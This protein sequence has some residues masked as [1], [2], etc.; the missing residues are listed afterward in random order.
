MGSPYSPYRL[1]PS[2]SRGLDDPDKGVDL[3]QKDVARLQN[4]VVDLKSQLRKAEDK[5]NELEKEQNARSNRLKAD[6]YENSM[7][8]LRE[9]QKGHNEV[10]E[11]AAKRIKFL[12]SGLEQAQ[13]EIASLE[14][15]ATQLEAK[16][17]ECNELQEVASV[18]AC[19]AFARF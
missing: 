12:E 17:A 15:A 3:L 10:Q 8:L 14:Q 16:K 7:E 4:E 2:P 13:A 18:L 11:A 5:C 1:S 19:S 6:V 9:V